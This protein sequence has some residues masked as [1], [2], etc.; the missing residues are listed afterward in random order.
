MADK[1]I[2]LLEQDE[3]GYPPVA[4]E[5]VRVNHLGGD[6][7][8]IDNIPFFSSEATLGDVVRARV[9]DGE[10]R[11]LETLRESKNSLIRV[12]Y[13]DG[14]DATALRKRLD[15]TGCSTEHEALH[16]L[17]AVSVPPTVSLSVVLAALE[18]DYSNEQVDYEEPILRQ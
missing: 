17:F 12:V 14:A 7:Y 13:F 11:Y 9:V 6:E 4:A 8:E 1:I 18:P 16:G 2:F 3:D 5:G 15:A 10:L